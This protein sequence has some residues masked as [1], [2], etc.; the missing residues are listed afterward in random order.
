[1]PLSSSNVDRRIPEALS[2]SRKR[3]LSSKANTF[4]MPA[5]IAA[6]LA[7]HA[8]RRYAALPYGGALIIYDRVT[9]VFHGRASTRGVRERSG[10]MSASDRLC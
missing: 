4:P 1:M 10:L 2:T 9:D 6:L 5:G 8:V 7:L 3:N